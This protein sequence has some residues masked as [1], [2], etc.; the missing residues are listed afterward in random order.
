MKEKISQSVAVAGA[1]IPSGYTIRASASEK[2]GEND[3]RR[4]RWWRGWERR[5]R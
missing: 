3:E 5:M 1:L 4:G 2:R